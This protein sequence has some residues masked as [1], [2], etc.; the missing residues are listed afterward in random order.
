MTDQPPCP[1]VSG[2]GLTCRDHAGH[3]GGHLYSPS[4]VW[5]AH[6]KWFTQQWAGREVA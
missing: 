4:G 6:A 2:S 3:P 5:E 1:Q